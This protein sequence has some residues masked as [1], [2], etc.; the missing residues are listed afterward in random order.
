MREHCL[1][2]LMRL[3]FKQVVVLNLRVPALFAATLVPSRLN[4]RIATG[5]VKNGPMQWICYIVKAA[6]VRALLDG[7]LIMMP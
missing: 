3:Q 5:A 2:Y 4:H 6:D 7:Y 1:W